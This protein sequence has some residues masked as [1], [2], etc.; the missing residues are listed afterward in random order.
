MDGQASVPLELAPRTNYFFHLPVQ[1]RSVV[2]CET[3]GIG[4]VDLYLRFDIPVEITKRNRV[5][6]SSETT[7]SREQCTVVVPTNASVLHV[8]M[9]PYQGSVA[10]ASVVCFTT[11]STDTLSPTIVRTDN[12]N[13]TSYPSTA[14]LSNLT[15]A[16]SSPFTLI[17]APREPAKSVTD[18]INA[19]SGSETSNYRGMPASLWFTFMCVFY[20]CSR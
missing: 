6:C 10:D 18:I 7:S 9:I 11:L 16:P 3:D 17:P 20:A 13:N 19:N 15:T 5:N 8:S 2:T 4:D 1:P 12:F 14:P